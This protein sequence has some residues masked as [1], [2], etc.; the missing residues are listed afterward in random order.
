MANL[1]KLARAPGGCTPGPLLQISPNSQ[2]RIWTSA[3]RRQICLAKQVRWLFHATLL[4]AKKSLKNKAKD[5]SSSLKTMGRQS[6]A[7]I[8]QLSNL[9]KSKNTHI[10]TF[11]DVFDEEDTNSDDEDFP[12]LMSTI[13]SLSYQSS[14][15]NRAARFISAYG[16]GLSG[17][18]AAWANRKYHSH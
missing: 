4:P 12:D 11:N 7:T 6:K 3:D 10:P 5:P 14:Y 2:G 1:P 8:S 13:Y 9:Q 18:E 15:A 16:Q 17:P